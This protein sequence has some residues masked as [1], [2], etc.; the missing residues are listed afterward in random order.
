MAEATSGSISRRELAVGLPISLIAG[1]V[2]GTIGTFKHQFGISAVTGTG[3]PIGLV[4]A[5]AMVLV[6]LVALRVAF[7]TRWYAVAAAVGVVA[8]IALLTQK[9]ASG[10]S[11]VILLNTAGIVWTFAPVLIAAVIVAWPRLGRRKQAPP[12]A[13]GILEHDNADPIGGAKD[14]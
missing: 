7:P 2:V 3:L 13:D 14:D 11:S 12:D 6:F 4:L 9:G 1:L 5:L 10:G 8:A